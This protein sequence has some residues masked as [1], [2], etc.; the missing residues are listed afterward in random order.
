M[1]QRH[2]LAIWDYDSVWD[3]QS[4]KNQSAMSTGDASLR[5]TSLL[6][7]LGSNTKKKT[8]NNKIS[9]STSFT[10]TRERKAARKKKGKKKS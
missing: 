10:S 6:S 5:L 4:N 9:G 8:G 1:V 7:N 2:N 3:E